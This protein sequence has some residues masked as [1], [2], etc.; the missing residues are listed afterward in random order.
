MAI[1]LDSEPWKGLGM[2]GSWDAAGSLETLLHL[3]FLPRV[4][5]IAGVESVR[6]LD[7]PDLLPDDVVAWLQFDRAPP[8]RH[9]LAHLTLAIQHET[10]AEQVDGL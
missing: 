8:L 5:D 2:T 3:L 6:V 7:R 1:A 9:R 10:C 4:V